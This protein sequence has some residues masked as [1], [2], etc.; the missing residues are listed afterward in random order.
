VSL[1]QW[2]SAAG[3]GAAQAICSEIDLIVAWEKEWG[4]G[5]RLF[6][7][8]SIPGH[9]RHSKRTVNGFVDVVSGRGDGG[10]FGLS[11]RLMIGRAGRSLISMGQIAL[12]GQQ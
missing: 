10:E 2:M 4:L 9:N 1:R 3:I 7:L 8:Y 12:L 6:G 5:C 11:G